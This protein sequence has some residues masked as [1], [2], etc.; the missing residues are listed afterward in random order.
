MDSFMPDVKKSLKF[1]MSSIMNHTTHPVSFFNTSS[2][3]FGFCYL[4]LEY[5]A[6]G[7]GV[8]IV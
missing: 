6:V 2:I 1:L 3:F 8:S 4:V 7:T 5:H